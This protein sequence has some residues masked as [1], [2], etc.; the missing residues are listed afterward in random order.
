MC[1]E[2]IG[3]LSFVRGCNDLGLVVVYLSEALAPNEFLIK[4]GI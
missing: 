2:T 4:V 3:A 1:N